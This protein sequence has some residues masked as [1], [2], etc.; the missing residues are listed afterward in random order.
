M[1]TRELREA[2]AKLVEEARQILS[3]ASDEKRSMTAEEDAKW[4]AIHADVDRLKAQIDTLERQAA[5]EA[6]LR[7]APEPENKIVTPAFGADEQRRAFRAWAAQGSTVAVSAEDL[8][9]ARKYGF[10]GNSL[11]LRALNAT[12]TSAGQYSVP[13]EMMAAFSE[14]LKWWGPVRNYATVLRTASGAPL[15]IPTVDDTSNSGAILAE[16][17]AVTTTVDPS[18]GQVVLDSYKYSSKLVLVS[19]E[20]LQD[21]AIDLASMLGRLLGTR[22]ARATNAHFT[23]GTG[24]AQPNGIVTASTLGK[25]ATA[26][27]AFTYS[28]IVDLLH[29]VDPAYRPG[30]A[31]LAND[32]I[33][34]AIKKFTDSQN[35]PI[36]APSIRDG[37][38]DRLLGYPVIANNDM[39]GTLAT[40]NKIM[41]FGDPKYYYVREAG[42]VVVMRLNE[43]YA[44]QHSVAFVAFQRTDGDLI[45]TAAVKHLKLA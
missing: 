36:W 11:E 9:L 42:D 12:T 3:K 37:Q 16:N 23:T 34:G 22:I 45:Q 31:F 29:S 20:L 24:S 32:A 21:S 14:A 6:E 10:G 8:E 13:D 39:T 38:P 41:L 35:L 40:G 5:A 43:R 26:T 30:S 44:D 28:E 33:I 18:F 27:N 2:R 25:T 15:P 17:T 1:T 19:V 4:T 7:T